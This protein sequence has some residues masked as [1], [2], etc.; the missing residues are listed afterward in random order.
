MFREG[1]GLETSAYKGLR[2]KER[3]CKPRLQ[4]AGLETQPT[5]GFRRA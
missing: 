3:G 1:A 5:G 4:G 2:E